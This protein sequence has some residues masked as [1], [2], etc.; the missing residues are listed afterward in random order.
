MNFLNN[1]L[2]THISEIQFMM[3]TILFSI[4]FFSLKTFNIQY[5]EFYRTTKASSILFYSK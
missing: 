4:G 2:S 5:F 1:V 3:V